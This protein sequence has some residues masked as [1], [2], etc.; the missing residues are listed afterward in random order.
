MREQVSEL[1]VSGT[2]NEFRDA[3]V[4]DVDEQIDEPQMTQRRFVV[5]NG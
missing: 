3:I 1:G 4:D 2:A 5:G